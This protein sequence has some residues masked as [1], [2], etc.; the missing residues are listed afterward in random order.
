MIY[1]LERCRKE[2]P[3]AYPEQ[4][5]PSTLTSV[6]FNLNLYKMQIYILSTTEPTRSWPLTRFS[7]FLIYKWM[8]NSGRILF[9][10]DLPRKSAQSAITST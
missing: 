3:K 1:G 7:K 8:D 4:A 6:T 2:Y 5:E 10:D 9:Q